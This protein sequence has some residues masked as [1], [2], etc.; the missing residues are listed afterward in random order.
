MGEDVCPLPHAGPLDPALRTDR[1]NLTPAHRSRW[2]RNQL[3]EQNWPSGLYQFDAGV[4]GVPRSAHAFLRETCDRPQLSGPFWL[5]GE[6]NLRLWQTGIPRHAL[7]ASWNSFTSLG[8]EVDA[9]AEFV[10][11][12]GRPTRKREQ[13]K[14]LW[15]QY[16]GPHRSHRF[17]NKTAEAA[18]EP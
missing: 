5:E 16:Y 8:G 12:T 15:E 18:I 4:L 1:L 9:R 14:R 17:E 13:L 6:L 2:A 7:P 11:V 10:H 3:A